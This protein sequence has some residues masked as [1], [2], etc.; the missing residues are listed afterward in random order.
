MKVEVIQCDRCLATTRADSRE[1][2]SYTHVSVLKGGVCKELDLCPNDADAFKNWLG[3]A[4]VVGS[5]EEPDEQ[6]EVLT[7]SWA[8]HVNT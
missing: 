3:S 2:V 7:P 1:A 4:Q 6:T 8:G 5:V